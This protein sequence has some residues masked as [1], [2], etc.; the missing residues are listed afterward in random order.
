MMARPSRII[1]SYTGTD[2]GVCSLE[3]FL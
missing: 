1:V 2:M 3:L